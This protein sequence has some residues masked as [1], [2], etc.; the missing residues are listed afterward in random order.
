[1]NADGHL[2]IVDRLKDM[3][4]SGALDPIR[5]SGTILKVLD[6]RRKSQQAP[7]SSVAQQRLA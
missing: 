7:P 3:I 6:D 2:F 4:I 5:L 1:M